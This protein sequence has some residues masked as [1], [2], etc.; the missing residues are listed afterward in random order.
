[1][2]QTAY[3]IHRDGKSAKFALTKFTFDE[4]ETF[5]PQI[6]EM[7]DAV[8]HT[9]KYWTK[10]YIRS[11]VEIGSLDV[12]GMGPPPKAVLIFFTQI[13]IYPAQR[14]LHVPW[15]AGSFDPEMAGLFAATMIN[16]AQLAGCE[17]ITIQGRPGWEP[18]FKRAGMV[19]EAIVWSYPVPKMGLN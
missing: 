11:A 19:R 5:W 2:K 9:W 17:T 1:M 4:F 12:W 6:E 15:G 14:V 7:L 3:D 13:G 10:E 16:Y 18:Y 8:P